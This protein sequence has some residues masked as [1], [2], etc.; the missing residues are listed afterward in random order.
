M[1]NKKEKRLTEMYISRR[2]KQRRKITCIY[3]KKRKIHR[4]L[5]MTS[6]IE[7]TTVEYS[8]KRKECDEI[9]R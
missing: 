8:I 3:I 7:E 6:C 2:V 1:K 5:T 4:C 9:T